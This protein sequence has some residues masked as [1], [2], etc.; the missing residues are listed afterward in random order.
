MD[1]VYVQR[2]VHAY[3]LRRN[4]AWTALLKAAEQQHAVRPLTSERLDHEA[5]SY[6]KLFGAS[7]R[8]LAVMLGVPVETIGTLRR[9][10]AELFVVAEA[11]GSPPEEIFKRFVNYAAV[12]KRVRNRQ[13]SQC[14]MASTRVRR[15]IR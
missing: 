9:M 7:E 10:L 1:D 13:T 4:A 5:D 8:E 11:N 12:H 3:N 14:L 6:K 2:G 15:A